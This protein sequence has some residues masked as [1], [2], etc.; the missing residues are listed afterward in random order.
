MS[1]VARIAVAVFCLA[2]ITS[3]HISISPSTADA[4][5]SVKHFFRVPHACGSVPTIGITVQVPTEVSAIQPKQHYPWVLSKTT[6]LLPT[7]IT[8]HGTVIT[9]T[10]DTFTWMGTNE[11]ALAN[12]WLDEF[13]AMVTYDK[14]RAKPGMKLYWPV[15]QFC[16][17]GQTNW[18]TIPV[19]GQSA[20]SPAPGVTI[21]TPPAA[22]VEEWKTS[23]S[24]AVASIVISVATLVGFVY[25]IMFH[26]PRVSLKIQPQLAAS[27]NLQIK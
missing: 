20:S 9:T 12:D 16:V 1:T 27:A 4:G 17:V 5:V 24:V 14:D 6:R 22:A 3:A 2:C 10:I 15:W 25:Q 23:D 19:A 11:T 21:N 18:T 13:E 7:P 26:L 8:N